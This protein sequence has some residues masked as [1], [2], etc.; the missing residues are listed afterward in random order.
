M[1]APKRAPMAT[2]DLQ[3]F[4]YFRLLG[5]LLAHL[6]AARTERERAALQ[7]P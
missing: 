2:P 4:K 3:D 1:A 5:P 7:A 6:H